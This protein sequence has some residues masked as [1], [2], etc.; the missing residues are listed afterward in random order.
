MKPYTI[1]QHGQTKWTLE[2]DPHCFSVYRYTPNKE[3][4]GGEP[5][6]KHIGSYPSIASAM[7]GYAGAYIRNS[8]ED[9]PEALRKAIEDLDRVAEELKEVTKGA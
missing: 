8:E 4:L 7:T 1:R 3:K 5:Y 6:K 9:L 2:S